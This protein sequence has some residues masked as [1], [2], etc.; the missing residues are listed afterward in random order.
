MRTEDHKESSHDATSTW[1]EMKKEMRN[2]HKE[3]SHHA[4]WV[5]RDKMKDLRQTE[6]IRDYVKTFSSLL[7]DIKDMSDEDKF[8]N[9]VSILKP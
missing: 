2:D 1:E 5:A 7:W 4:S 3:S 9:F 8:F 6:I